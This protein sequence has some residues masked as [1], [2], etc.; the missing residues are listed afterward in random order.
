MCRE[1]L[2]QA[3]VAFQV[4][5][6]TVNAAEADL[7]NM[8]MPDIADMLRVLQNNEKE[9]L[10]LTLILQALRQGYARGSF[11]WQDISAVSLTPIAAQVEPDAHSCHRCTSAEPTKEEYTAAKGEALQGL[12]QAIENINEVLEEIRYAEDDLTGGDTV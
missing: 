2:A 9:K 11:S 7:R 4:C 8:H 3:T 6:E 12:Q 5:S 10:R 1:T